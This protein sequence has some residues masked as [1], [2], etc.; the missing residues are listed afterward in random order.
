MNNGRIAPQSNNQ[1]IK[2]KTFL[3][4]VIIWLVATWLLASAASAITDKKNK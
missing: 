1:K 2:M 3:S 4:L